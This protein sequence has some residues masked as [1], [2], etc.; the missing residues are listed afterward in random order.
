MTSPI[1]SMQEFIQ[2]IDEATIAAEKEPVFIAE[3]GH[4]SHVLMNFRD[5]QRL[6]REHR[7][8]AELLAVPDM[9]G[10]DFELVRSPESA[11]PADFS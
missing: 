11:E 1:L 8:M 4:A 7:N 2:N 9:A 5:Y 10:I 3:Q 6:I